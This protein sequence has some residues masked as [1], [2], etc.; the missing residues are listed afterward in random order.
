MDFAALPFAEY[1]TSDRVYR[2]M[3]DYLGSNQ[4]L[5]NAGALSGDL[6]LT[7]GTTYTS[8]SEV[9]S[10]SREAMRTLRI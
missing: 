8:G 3:Q 6:Y 7:L 10:I 9:I 4:T 5:I 1:A 2:I